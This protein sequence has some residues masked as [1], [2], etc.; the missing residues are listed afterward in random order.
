MKV[1]AFLGETFDEINNYFYSMPP[2]AKFL[3]MTFGECNV[4]IIS[5]SKTVSIL[6]FKPNSTIAGSNFYK[7]PLP[8]GCTTKEFYKRSIF[9]RGFFRNFCDFCDQVIADNP[10]AIF[11]V[12]TPSPGGVIFAFRVIKAGRKLLHH[13]CGDARDTWRDNKYQGLNKVLAFLFSKVVVMQ[14]KS[15]IKYNNTVNL[16]SGSRLFD[17]ASHYSNKTHQFLD[18][19]TNGVDCEK[20]QQPSQIKMRISFIGRIVD[21]KG[22]FELLYAMKK[23]IDSYGSVCHLTVVGSGPDLQHVTLKTA[24]LDLAEYI[25]FSGVLDSSGVSNI[26]RETDVVVIPSKTNEGFPRVIFESWA[27]C[28]PVIVSRI[29]GISAFVVD[30]KNALIVEP[31]SIEG[32]VEALIQ[33]LDT[34]KYIALKKG[35]IQARVVATQQYWSNNLQEIIK[36][37]FINEN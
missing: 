32:I 1:L 27:H 9:Q 25:S 17:F 15:I 4:K 20:Y 16:T 7:A 28:V 29:G 33:C 3:E 8:P 37:E 13:I 24:E 12:R 5:P 23:L 10:D 21:D 36:L 14:L 34:N 22:I 35:V 6:D 11:W 2:N 26:L 19:V 30:K 31:G 18:V